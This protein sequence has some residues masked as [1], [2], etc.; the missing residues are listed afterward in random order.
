MDHCNDLSR[1]KVLFRFEKKIILP[2][3]EQME[4]TN[5]SDDNISHG[6][7]S[8]ISW[9]WYRLWEYFSNKSWAF[10]WFFSSIN[11]VKLVSKFCTDWKSW[12]FIFLR[13]SWDGFSSYW[14]TKQIRKLIIKIQ[15]KHNMII[16]SKRYN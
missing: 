6:I 16:W 9:Y 14:G 12:I 5:A 4:L 15:I 7:S 3:V 10:E 2:V 1:E 11:F 13:S 8:S